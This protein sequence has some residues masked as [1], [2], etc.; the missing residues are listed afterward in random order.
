MYF[1]SISLFTLHNRFRLHSI[2]VVLALCIFFAHLSL[3]SIFFLRSKFPFV[4]APMMS[5]NDIQQTF[6]MH[7]TNQKRICYCINTG[8]TICYANSCASA[9]I[10]STDN[11]NRSRY[12]NKLFENLFNCLDYVWIVAE[13]VKITF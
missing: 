6:Y 13:T 2:C 4:F 5:Y 1:I 8:F 12:F 11:K 7:R 3:D 9:T 10:S